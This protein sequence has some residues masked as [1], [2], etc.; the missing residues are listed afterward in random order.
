MQTPEADVSCFF[1]LFFGAPDPESLQTWIQRESSFYVMCMWYRVFT[2][3][4]DFLHQDFPLPSLGQL[5]MCSSRAWTIHIVKTDLSF[6]VSVTA[7]WDHR[8][9]FH[10]DSS[11][12]FS[13]V[14]MGS[15]NAVNCFPPLT[16][17]N[18]FSIH[19]FPHVY[20]V[21]LIILLEEQVFLDRLYFIGTLIHALFGWG[22]RQGLL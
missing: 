14:Q 15:P 16:L 2:L 8:P 3:M 9:V 13:P 7:V 17:R 4:T 22:G 6:S 10:Q 1:L 20:A 19:F 12:A 21:L 5:A 18:F 11:A